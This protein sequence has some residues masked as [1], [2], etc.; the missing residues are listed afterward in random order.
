MLRSMN[1][2]VSGMRAHQTMMD[3]VGNNIANVNTTGYKASSTQFGDL[4]SQL[5]RGAGS[6]GQDTAGTNPAQVGLGVRLQ[7]I[8]TNFSQGALQLTG[9]STDAGIEGDGFFVVARGNQQLF[10]RA[11]SFALDVNGNMVNGDGLRV[12]GWQADALGV[13]NTNNSVGD[14][15]LPIAQQ[16][17]PVSTSSVALGGNLQSTRPFPDPLFANITVYDGQGRPLDMQLE[18]DRTG[19][20]AWSVQPRNAATGTAIGGATALTWN[21]ATNTWTPPTVT[22]T[23]ADLNAIDPAPLVARNFTGPIAVDLG[24]VTQFGTPTAVSALSQNG[25]EAGSLQSFAIALDGTITGAFTNGVTQPLARMALAIFNNPMGLEKVGGTAFRQ[26]VNSGVAQLGE[27]GQGGRGTTAGGTLETSN[28]DLAQEF[29]NLI[30]AQRGFQSNSR[31]I[32]TA[33]EMLQELVNLRR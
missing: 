9:R 28:V 8:T 10:T 23:Q 3:V 15:N 29:T 24:Q 17:P 25:N 12:Q 1:A 14:I 33:D 7:S 13:I 19:S 2:G 31:V 26:T 22:V 30:I 11:G 27:A 21:P 32:T 6:G 4:L 18:I 16:I 5:L 20:N